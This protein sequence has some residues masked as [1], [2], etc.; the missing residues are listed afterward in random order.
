MTPQQAWFMRYVPSKGF[1]DL[2]ATSKL[3]EAK[4]DSARWADVD[5]DG[6]IDLV[7]WPRWPVSDV[8]R[9]NGDG[10]LSTPPRNTAWLTRVRRLISPPSTSTASISASTWRLPARS[11]DDYERNQFGG[12]FAADKDVAASWPAAERILADDFNG[13]GLPDFVFIAEKRRTVVPNAGTDQQQIGTDLDTIDAV[14]TIDV[15]NDGW[16]DVVMADAQ[17]LH[18]SGT[19]AKSKREVCRSDRTTSSHRT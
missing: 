18:Q 5:H 10:T 4:G 14:T 2:T 9:N 3:A 7:T 12:H 16:L 8:W 13:D 17:V 6:D 1:E 11:V 15:D 19:V